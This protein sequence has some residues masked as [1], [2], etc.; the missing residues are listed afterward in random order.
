[1]V[2]GARYSLK[3]AIGAWLVVRIRNW[4]GSHEKELKLRPFEGGPKEKE[5]GKTFALLS[6]AI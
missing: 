4:G 2:V 3:G 1:V 5:R 6:R